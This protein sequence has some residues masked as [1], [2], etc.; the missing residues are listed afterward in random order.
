MTAVPVIPIIFVFIFTS[1]I[2]PVSFRCSVLCRLDDFLTNAWRGDFFWKSPHPDLV[3]CGGKHI[4]L[5]DAANGCICWTANCIA[6]DQHFHA[7]VF[8]ATGGVI[9]GS[10]W[11]CMAETLGADRF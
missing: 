7:P 4:A 6:R 3:H 1:C 5:A 9:V 2:S 10:Y 8:L 11:R